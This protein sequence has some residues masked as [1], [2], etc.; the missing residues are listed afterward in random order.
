MRLYDPKFGEIL[1][2]GVN[3]KNLDLQWYHEHVAIVNQNP[4]LFNCSI[5]DNIAY[6]GVGTVTKVFFFFSNSYVSIIAIIIII[7]F[8]T[9]Y[10]ITFIEFY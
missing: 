6:G 1:V 7:I 4:D 2:D 10:I 5:A 8:S 9:S 3:I